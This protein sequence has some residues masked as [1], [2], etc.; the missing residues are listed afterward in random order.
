MQLAGKEKI[1]KFADN[2]DYWYYKEVG[3]WDG[4]DSDK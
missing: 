1:Y 3:K 4:E 2:D